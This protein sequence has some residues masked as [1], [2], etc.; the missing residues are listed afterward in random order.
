MATSSAW[1]LQNEITSDYSLAK[2][3]THHSCL[4]ART[5]TCNDQNYPLGCCNDPARDFAFVNPKRP[6]LFGSCR[7]LTHYQ[8]A[9]K[10]PLKLR[11]KSFCPS[12][13]VLRSSLTI[14][15]EWLVVQTPLLLILK[16]LFLL[17]FHPSTYVL[18][19]TVRVRICLTAPWFYFFFFLLR[20]KYI[21]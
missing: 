21:I 14:S 9:I 20:L 1:A 3:I 12:R 5:V 6:V 4:P 15:N 7:R 16:P 8:P 13:C 10:C 2:T 19:L 11:G 18:L 17:L